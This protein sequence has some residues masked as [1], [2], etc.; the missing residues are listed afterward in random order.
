MEGLDRSKGEVGYA[1]LDPSGRFAS[2]KLLVK[3]P[4]SNWILLGTGSGA[5]LAY[6]VRYQDNTWLGQGS[7]NSRYPDIWLTVGGAEDYAEE[8][9]ARGFGAGEVVPL[10]ALA[11]Y[12]NP[13]IDLSTISP[14]AAKKHLDR[15]SK[16][17]L[18]EAARQALASPQLSYYFLQNNARRLSDSERSALR[19]VALRIA[20]YAPDFGLAEGPRDDTRAAACLSP[21]RASI[22]AQLV[23]KCPRDDTRKAA[24]LNPHSAYTYATYV[25]KGPRD[26]TR[27]AACQNPWPAYNYAR[28]VDKGPRDDTRAAACQNPEWAYGYAKDIDKAPRDDTRAAAIKNLGVA[29]NYSKDVDKKYHPDTEA[30]WFHHLDPKIKEPRLESARLK[31]E[32]NFFN[33]NGRSGRWRKNFS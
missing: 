10:I 13:Q 23:D 26:D 32:K 24:C 12:H 22:Y 25:D 19:S 4:K 21:G 7:V 11:R 28:D 8:M 6:A 1:K 29:I 30:K 5:T 16:T 3:P 9:A 31:F 14:S 18:K 15:L 20:D 27:Q 17:D 2:T 33:R